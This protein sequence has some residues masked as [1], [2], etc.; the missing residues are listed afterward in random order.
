MF[1]E[2]NILYKPCIKNHFKKNNCI[3]LIDLKYC[4]LNNSVLIHLYFNTYMYMIFVFF[5]L[6]GSYSVSKG[7]QILMFYS[8]EIINIMIKSNVG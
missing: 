8:R 6:L 7:Y 5:E 4:G 1:H 3:Y 2:N